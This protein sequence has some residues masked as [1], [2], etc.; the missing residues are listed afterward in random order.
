MIHLTN[1]SDMCDEDNNP[2][3][4]YLYEKSCFQN[5]SQAQFVEY[6]LIVSK[7]FNNNKCKISCKHIT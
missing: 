6:S 3:N 7:N 5:I 4:T 2:T 1:Q